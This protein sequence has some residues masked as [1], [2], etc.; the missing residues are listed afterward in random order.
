MGRRSCQVAEV[1]R[2]V[3]GTASK[4]GRVVE[5]VKVLRRGW[6]V[7]GVSGREDGKLV[8]QVNGGR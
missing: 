1:G 6:G 2:Q 5:D 8:L 7:S 3:E 4:R